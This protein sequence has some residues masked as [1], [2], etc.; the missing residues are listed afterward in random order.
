MVPPEVGLLRDEEANSAYLRGN[1]EEGL[2]C[3]VEGVPMSCWSWGQVG[4]F[5]F[6]VQ[7]L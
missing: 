4:G 6:G 5:A 1:P 3:G 7:G 2:V